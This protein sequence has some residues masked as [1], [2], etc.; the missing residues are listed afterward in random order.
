M[1]Q[2][3][4]NEIMDK[5]REEQDK[6]NAKQRLNYA[7]RKTSGK[8]KINKIPPEDQKKRGPK[9]KTQLDPKTKNNLALILSSMK[10]Y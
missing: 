10:K 9:I 8:I 7:K 2:K 6:R 3:Q 5:M 4:I 1:E